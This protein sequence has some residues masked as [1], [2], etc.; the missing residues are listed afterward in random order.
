MARKTTLTLASLVGA[1][2]AG[3]P[4]LAQEVS[5]TLHHFLSPKSNAHQNML[6]PWVERVEAASD[7][8]IDIEIFPAMTLG[9]APPQLFRQVA[10]GVVDIVWTVN[11]YTPG[12]FPRSE[13]FE[14]PTVFTNDAAATNLAIAEMYEEW[15][16]PD[17]DGVHLLFGHVHAG[18]ALHTV[19]TEARSPDDTAGLKLRVPGPTGNAVVEALGATPVTMPV[20]SLPQSLSTGVVDG[21]LIPFEIIP[22]LQLQEVTGYQIEGPEMERFGTTAFQV[23]MNEDRWNSLPEDLQAVLTEASGGDW[24]REVGTVWTDADESAIAMASEAGNTHIVLSREE[25]DAFNAALQGVVEAW[26]AQHE[27]DFDARALVESA[28]ETIEKHK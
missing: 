6:V 11:G 2:L 27:G 25:M 14:L 4:A 9:G 3:T 10:D 20:P 24:L 17:Y 7:G 26:I 13:V 15:L 28:R 22:P 8:R 5:L 19:D 1:A 21:A 23:S 16:A 18:N 12:L